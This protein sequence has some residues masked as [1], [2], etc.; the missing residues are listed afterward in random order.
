MTPEPVVPFGD[1]PLPALL[2]Y[3]GAIA[4]VS[5][6]ALAV[7]LL[8]PPRRLEPVLLLYQLFVLLFLLGDTVTRFSSVMWVER[9]GIAL[10]YSGSIPAAAACWILALRFAEVQGR[11][12]PWAAPV[13]ERVPIVLSAVAWAVMIT[14]PLHGQFLTP[15]IGEHNIHH[16]AWFCTVPLGYAL[17]AGALGLHLLLAWSTPD[18]VVRGNA[19]LMAGAVGVTMGFNF[20]S[21]FESLLP[22]DPTVVGLGGASAIFLYG[23]YRT[24]LF[25]LLPVAVAE[26][27]RYDP[28]GQILV[29]LEGRWLRSN[30][31]AVKLLGAGLEQPGRDVIALLAARLEARSRGALDAEDLRR[32]LLG[33]PRARQETLGPLCAGEG[34]WVDVTATPIP[35]LEGRARAISLRLGDVSDR[36]AAE[37]QLRRARREIRNLVAERR[38]VDGLLGEILSHVTRGDRCDESERA[39]RALRAAGRTA[40]RARAL[41]GAVPRH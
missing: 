16:W 24:Q 4:L 8:R 30:P 13:W 34:H 10:L 32:R 25:S 21:Q 36:V 39:R 33:A 12:F 14:N 41:T 35:R 15:V 3:V 22:F 38:E 18:R 19:I 11:P 9:L 17:A 29:D 20:L 31:A 7:I 27:T 5:G 37:E 26:T 28:N 40:E 1:I 6:L 2:P 23:A